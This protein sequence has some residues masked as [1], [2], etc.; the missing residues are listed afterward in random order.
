M[1]IEAKFSGRV[2]K[3]Q[4]PACGTGLDGATSF[5]SERAPLE[6]DYSVC[7]Y[8]AAICRFGEHGQLVAA[9]MRELLA[10]QDADLEL[11]AY[12]MKMHTTARLMVREREKAAKAAISC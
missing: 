1:E 11:F 6:G 3:T 12:V 7:A 10:L 9:T 5:E 8:C 2:K 4:C